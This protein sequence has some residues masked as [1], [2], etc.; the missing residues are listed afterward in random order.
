MLFSNC[1][2]ADKV[3]YVRSIANYPGAINL[4]FSIPET[5]TL[6]I[7]LASHLDVQSPPVAAPLALSLLLVL[8]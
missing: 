2:L 6:N 8:T 3:F 7:T 4:P 5:H 1:H